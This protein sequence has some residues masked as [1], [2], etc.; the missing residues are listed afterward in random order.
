VL[1]A[2]GI[3]PRRALE[4]YYNSGFVGV[5][6]THLMFLGEW[7]RMMAIVRDVLGAQHHHI[8][9]GGATT[10]FHSTDQDALNMALMCGDTPI[11][12]A[13]GEAMD[14]LVGGHHLSHAVGTPKPWQGSAL[15]Q[16]LRGYPPSVPTK[17]FLL[18]A[19]TPIALFSASELRSR[20][21]ALAL[22]AFVGRF[23]RRS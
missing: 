21:R 17:N 1:A 13:G 9:A 3:A 7:R 10:L 14:F 15:R 2:R 19:A 11:N 4:R 5:P 6:R 23:Y 20:R 18:H 8:K 12:A 16:A 22:A